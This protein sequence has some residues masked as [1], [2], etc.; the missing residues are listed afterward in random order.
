MDE[1]IQEKVAS[2]NNEHD[3]VLNNVKEEHAISVEDLGNRNLKEIAVLRSKL[4]LGESCQMKL[5]EAYEDKLHDVTSK[6]PELQPLHN[7]VIEKS[8]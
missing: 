1:D 7:E 5:K 2:I 4:V 8:K 6:Y 3:T